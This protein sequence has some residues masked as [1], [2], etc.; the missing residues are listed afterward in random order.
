MLGG[1]ST[2]SRSQLTEN[3]IFVVR[4]SERSEAQ[5]R[6]PV[7]LPVRFAAGSLDFARDDKKVS[8]E[9]PQKT[10]IILRKEADIGNIE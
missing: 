2:N 7:A 1:S 8:C 6:S 4:H 3:F 10:Q 5:L 9:L